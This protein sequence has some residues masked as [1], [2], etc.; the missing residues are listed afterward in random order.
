[1]KVGESCVDP[2]NSAK[3]IGAVLDSNLDLVKHVNDTRRTCY[4]YLHSICKIRS[5]ITQEAAET[6]VQRY[7]KITPPRKS[8]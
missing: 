5:C 2:V 4:M 7:E 8:K 6:F 1:M 3:N